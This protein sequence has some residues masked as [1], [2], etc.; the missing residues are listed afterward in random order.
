MRVRVSAG[1]SECDD[2][3]AWVGEGNLSWAAL[4]IVLFAVCR[5]LLR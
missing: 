3:F 5:M 2:V 1:V 4:G